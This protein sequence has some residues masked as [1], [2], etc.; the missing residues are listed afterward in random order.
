MTEDEFVREMLKRKSELEAL[1]AA[2]SGDPV[3]ADD[4][5]QESVVIMLDKRGEIQPGEGFLPWSRAVAYNVFRD[6]R[7]NRARQKVHLLSDEALASVAEAFEHFEEEDVSERLRS[8]RACREKLLPAHQNML[9]MRYEGD[10]SI[11]ELAGALSR[12]PNAVEAMLYRIRKALLDCI[13]LRLR[14][15]GIP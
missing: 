11:N 9:T 10:M 2:L 7:K 4:L 8:L 14:S 3:L 12:S 13:E 1:L 15:A 5:F 6:H